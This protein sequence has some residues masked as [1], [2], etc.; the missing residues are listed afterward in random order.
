MILGG[1]RYYYLAHLQRGSVRVQVG[2]RVER[3]QPLARCGN[4]GNSDYPHLHLHATR[5]P[6]FGEGVGENITF[7]GIDVELAFKRFR[8]VEWPLIRGLFVANSLA[9]G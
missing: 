6:R 3:G 8:N 5:S 4:S 7:S 9:G 2:E 1:D